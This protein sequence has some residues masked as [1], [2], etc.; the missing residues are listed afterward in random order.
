VFLVFFLEES[1]GKPWDSGVPKCNCQ[2]AQVLLLRWEGSRVM[3]RKSG[4]E[5]SA[6]SIYD[7]DIVRA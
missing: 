3:S 1:E 4:D 6:R 5:P 7:I 2:A